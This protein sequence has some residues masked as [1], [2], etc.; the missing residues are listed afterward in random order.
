MFRRQRTIT[1]VNL[2]GLAV[3]IACSSLILLRVLNEM[4]FDNF[5]QNR[6]RIFR[7]LVQRKGTDELMAIMPGLWPGSQ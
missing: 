7:I 1:L 3:G 4:S 2:L 5:R 6:D